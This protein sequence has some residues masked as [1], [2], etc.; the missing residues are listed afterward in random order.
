VT[1]F[2][3][4]RDV[5]EAMHLVSTALTGLNSSIQS[6]VD[7]AQTLTVV[8]KQHRQ[9]FPSDLSENALDL[10]LSA[11]LAVGELLI[12][13]PTKSSWRE[14]NDLLAG[15][16]LSAHQL[17]PTSTGVHLKEIHESIVA[18]ARALLARKSSQ[19]RQRAEFDPR[20]FDAL[21]VAGDIPAFWDL[22]KPALIN[23]FTSVSQASAVDRDELEVLW[24]VYNDASVTFSKP[25]SDLNSFDVALASTLEI[26]DRAI[27]PAHD[28]LKNIVKGLIVRAEKKAKPATKSLKSIVGSW[29]PQSF[30][31]FSPVDDDVTIVATSH[32]KVL[33]LTW[34]ASKVQQSGV[35]GGW[36]KEF[37]ARTGLSAARKL[38]ADAI[39]EQVFAERTAQHLLLN[40]CGE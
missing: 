25:L 39:A 10:Q 36:E 23:A 22:L 18:S 4:K 15:L 37:E 17:Q 3:S 35:S 9:A 1:S 8:T 2:D 26:V 21:A 33:P 7:Y 30:G 29:S 14:A 11:A 40:F 6:D 38:S 32:P 28:S 31:T 20:P 13:K 19:V 12:R 27:C 34:I 24:W 5:E 16:V